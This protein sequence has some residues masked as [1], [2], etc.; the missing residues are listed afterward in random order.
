MA[1]LS[2]SGRYYSSVFQYHHGRWNAVFFATV[3]AYITASRYRNNAIHLRFNIITSIQVDDYKTFFLYLSNCVLR[4]E[5]S[6][7]D[8]HS[9]QAK[10]IHLPNLRDKFRCKHKMVDHIVRRHWSKSR[11]ACEK[12]G[13]NTPM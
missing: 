3:L 13:K 5:K 6:D 4:H 12:A 11:F 8:I 9:Y 10:R 2:L 7:R 1:L